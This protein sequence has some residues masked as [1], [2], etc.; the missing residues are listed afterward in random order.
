MVR[1][2]FQINR[3]V[4]ENMNSYELST[5]E[6]RTKLC[7]TSYSLG[8]DLVVLI[9]NEKAHLGA[10]AVAE[11]APKQKRV[12]TSVFTRLGHKDDV[13]AQKAAYLI[14]KH[15]RKP[16]CVV[17]GIHVDNITETEIKHIVENSK[18]LVEDFISRDCK[19]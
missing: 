3:S 17:A 15:T 1:A 4:A 5:G 11:Y 18:K 13:V 8:K 14:G 2:R 6:G 7:L 10:V 19:I 16:V 9:Y 12:S